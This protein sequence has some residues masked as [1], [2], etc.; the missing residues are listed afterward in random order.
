MCLSESFRP[1]LSCGVATADP[2]HL[3]EPD[4]IR[5]RGRPWRGSVRSRKEQAS[6]RDPGEGLILRPLAAGPRRGAR[7]GSTSWKS[8]G[9]ALPGNLT[10]QAGPYPTQGGPSASPLHHPPPD[11]PGWADPT[12]VGVQVPQVTPPGMRSLPSALG[13][14]RKPSAG[15]HLNRSVCQDPHSGMF[16]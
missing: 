4:C 6:S 9:V 5:D 3:P 7:A 2:S 1:L 14:S 13:A 12:Q 11:S 16:R 8:K 15:Q 10:Q